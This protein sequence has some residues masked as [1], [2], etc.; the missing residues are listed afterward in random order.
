LEPY[1]ERLIVSRKRL[2][3]INNIIKNAQERLD[4]V[5]S[6]LGREAERSMAAAAASQAHAEA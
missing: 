3:A 6:G 2:A 1:V 5:A 4:R